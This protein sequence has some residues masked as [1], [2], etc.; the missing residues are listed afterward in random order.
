VCLARF[1]FQACS[2]DHSDI[3]PFRINQLRTV[4]NRI[5]QNLPSRTS[6]LRCPVAAIVCRHMRGDM[7]RNCVR[8]SNVVRSLTAISL[9]CHSAAG[10]R[11]HRKRRF[12]P[13][14]RD[15]DLPSCMSVLDV[16][17]GGGNLAQRESAVNHRSH[18]SSFAELLQQQQV[19]LVGLH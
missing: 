7:K 15:D 16:A 6:D 19:S 3:S 1:A 9:S 8:P 13:S 14:N 4:W 18:L 2:I 11:R 17:D 12:V 5:A 10:D